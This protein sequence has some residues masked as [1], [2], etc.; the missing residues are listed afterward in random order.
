[1]K[2]KNII[3][4]ALIAALVGLCCLLG[5]RLRAQREYWSRE[6][7]FHI[8]CLVGFYDAAE[9]GAY[10]NGRDIRDDMGALLREDVLVYQKQF[11]QDFGTNAEFALKFNEA[12][13][14]YLS[15]EAGQLP[16]IRSESTNDRPNTALEPTPTAP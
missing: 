14:I 6:E 3:I 10:Q 9:R 2:A 13:L 8:A 16:P 5:Y 12:Q 15:V 4:I 11:G 7:R 1:V